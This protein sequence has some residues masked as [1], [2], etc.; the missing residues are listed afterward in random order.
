MKL[1]TKDMALVAM[2]TSLTAIGAFISIPLGP[3]PITLQSLFVIL[4]GLILGPKL[5]ALSQIVYI[6]LGLVGAPI[7]AGFTGG[8]QSLMTP[9][10][11]FIIGFVFAAYVVGKIAHSDNGLSAR[12][13]WMGSLVGSLVIY[14]FGLPYMYYMLNIVMGNDFSFLNIMQMGCFMFLPGD[15]AKLAISSFAAIKILPVLNNL[16]FI[17]N[18]KNN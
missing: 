6:L 7:F 4:S 16:G 2:F 17:A 18:T 5:G 13:I 14:L 1:S 3:V 8:P 12:R 9:S 15:L 11:G 10:F